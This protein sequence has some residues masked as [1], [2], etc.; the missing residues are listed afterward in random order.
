MKNKEKLAEF[1]FGKI[2]MNC[3]CLLCQIPQMN[4]DKMMNSVLVKLSLRWL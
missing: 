2:L 4:L 3:F 1:G